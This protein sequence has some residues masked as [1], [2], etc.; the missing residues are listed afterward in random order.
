MD[1]RSLFTCRK[2]DST[3][4]KAVLVSRIRDVWR[5]RA[6]IRPVLDALVEQSRIL[7]TEFAPPA[8]L[9]CSLVS[10]TLSLRRR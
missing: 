4:Q 1:N 10:E 5:V 8:R 9:R 7:A 6:R 3:N 2:A